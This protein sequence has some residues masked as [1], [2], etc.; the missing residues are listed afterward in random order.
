[1]YRAGQFPAERVAA[2][3]PAILLDGWKPPSDASLYFSSFGL[4]VFDIAFAARILRN[5]KTMNIGT[6]LPSI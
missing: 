5:A 1:M 4:N 2:D 6:L 3:L